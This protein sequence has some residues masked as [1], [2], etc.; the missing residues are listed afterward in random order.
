[1]ICSRLSYKLNPVFLGRSANS[2]KWSLFFYICQSVHILLKEVAIH[3][4]CRKR[5]T[6]FIL[7][8][9]CRQKIL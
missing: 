9:F 3:V 1:M 5:L 2:K 4:L 6:V 7:D 8:L